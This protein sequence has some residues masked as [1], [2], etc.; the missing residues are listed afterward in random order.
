MWKFSSIEWSQNTLRLY[1]DVRAVLSYTRPGEIQS[2]KSIIQNAFR[3]MLCYPDEYQFLEIW[4]GIDLIFTSVNFVAKHGNICH[5]VR[6]I[7]LRHVNFLTRR[8]EFFQVVC[9]F[10]RMN[11]AKWKQ[12]ISIESCYLERI[13]PWF[14]NFQIVT[15][16]WNN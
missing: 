16:T 15:K 12:S 2:A 8:G 14:Y 5:L 1:A 7:I 10:R 4:Y 3:A 13:V 11:K 9:K 6:L